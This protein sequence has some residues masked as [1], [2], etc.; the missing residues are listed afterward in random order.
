[1]HVWGTMGQFICIYNVHG[2][3]CALESDKH[4]NKSRNV[5]GSRNWPLHMSNLFYRY[6]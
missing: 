3:D 6:I 2:T 5:M 4:Y 1:M